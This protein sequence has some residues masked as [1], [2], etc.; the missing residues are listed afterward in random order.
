MELKTVDIP[1]PEGCNV[2]VGQA[3]FI[4]TAEDLAEIAVGS[5]PGIKFGLAFSEASGPCLVRTEGTDPA[6]V[7]QAAKTALD[8]GAG[9]SFV[10]FVRNAFPINL[11][12]QIKQ[13]P[14]VASVFCATA[15][16]V[17]LVV[18][19]TAK[20]RAIMGAVDGG[21]P[22]GVENAD[23]RQ[24]RRDLLRTFGYKFK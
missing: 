10:M 16:P 3:H 9:H 18:A 19:E 20:G 1:I 7:E 12:N 4:K 13:C 21:S 6:L 15:N 5:V 17:E 2:I 14:E 24:A 11:L 23:D 8:V 22:K